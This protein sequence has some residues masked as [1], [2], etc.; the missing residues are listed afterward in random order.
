[1]RIRY[2]DEAFVTSG[3]VVITVIDVVNVRMAVIDVVSAVVV[4]TLL[5]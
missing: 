3:I 2:V 4:V 1:M 5:P